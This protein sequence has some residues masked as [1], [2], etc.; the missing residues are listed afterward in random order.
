M[1]SVLAHAEVNLFSIDKDR[2]ITMAEGG[3]KWDSAIEESLRNK[4]L[5]IGK[6]AST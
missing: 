4:S 1:L 5:V 6:D 3:I 2:I